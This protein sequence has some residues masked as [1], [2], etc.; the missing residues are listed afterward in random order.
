MKK[1]LTICLLIATACTATAQ[2]LSSG[3]YTVSISKLTYS[4]VPGMFGNNFPGKQIKGIFTIKKGGVQTASQ[5]FTYLQL[6]ETSATLHLNFDETSSNALTYDFDTKKFEIEDYEYKAKKTKTK[7][8][9][10][11]SGVLVYAQ[12]LDE[13]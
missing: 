2:Q 10:I 3:I 12:W 5:E 6:F 9:L 11:L 7:E 13:E 8:D 1:L 4:D